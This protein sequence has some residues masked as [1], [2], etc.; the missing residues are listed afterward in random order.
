MYDLDLPV[1][2]CISYILENKITGM[3]EAKAGG[4]PPRRLLPSCKVS[5]Y[6]NIDLPGRSG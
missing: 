1:I 3:R 4:S 5:I 6:T 2:L